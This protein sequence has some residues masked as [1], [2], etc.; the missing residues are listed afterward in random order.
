MEPLRL[1]DTAQ[2]SGPDP[3]FDLKLKHL[4]F[5]QLTLLFFQWATA[6]FATALFWYQYPTSYILA[7]SVIGVCATVTI[8]LDIA[9]VEAHMGVPRS[10]YLLFPI[11][12]Q[13]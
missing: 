12:R 4:H 7:V 1:Q 10:P 3:D 11:V 2:D 8:Q 9:A 13:A 6:L 5:K